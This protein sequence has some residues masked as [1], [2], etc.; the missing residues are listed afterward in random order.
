M[1]KVSARKSPKGASRKQAKPANKNWLKP[2]LAKL[3][4]FFVAVVAVGLLLSGGYFV[5]N[6]VNNMLNVA[7][8][9]VEVKGVLRYESAQDIQK[10][11]DEYLLKG[12]VQA[13]LKELQQAL[14]DRPWIKNALLKR[15]LSNVL[16]VELEEQTVAAVWNDEYLVNEQGQLFKPEVIPPI[17]GL[18]RFESKKHEEVLTVYQKLKESFQNE[19]WVI[20]SLVIKSDSYVMAELDQQTLVVFQLDDLPTQIKHLQTVVAQ[21]LQGDIYKAQRID[22]RYSNG[23]AVALKEEK[24]AYMPTSLIGDK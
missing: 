4:I 12:Y 18:V 14:I 10:L 7:V 3:K 21:G 24:L 6:S 13:D 19:S 17:S 5:T 20:S 2:L 8:D 11:M 15:K 22:L 1:S 16:Q 23:V 9:S